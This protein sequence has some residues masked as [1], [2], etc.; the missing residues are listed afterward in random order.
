MH[1]VFNAHCLLKKDNVTVLPFKCLPS[2][3]FWQALPQQVGA[4]HSLYQLLPQ[5]SI[6]NDAIPRAAN[7]LGGTQGF[8]IQEWE[9]VL[10]YVVQA[11]SCQPYTHISITS[12]TKPTQTD[13]VKKL[14]LNKNSS[15][16]VQKRKNNHLF[17]FLPIYLQSYDFWRWGCM[18]AC[19]CCHS[20]SNSFDNSKL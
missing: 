5:H 8:C 20:C 11:T 4:N 16:S 19:Q 10:G 17:F 3:A 15:L 13:K 12:Q 1:S 18:S 6:G 2:S 14:S 9:N 7:L